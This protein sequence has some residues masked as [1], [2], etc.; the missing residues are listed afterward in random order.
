MT[1]FCFGHHILGSTKDYVG[2]VKFTNRND[3]H[4]G[5]LKCDGRSLDTTTYSDLFNVIGYSFGGSGSNFNLPKPGG[6]ILGSTGSGAGLTTRTMGDISGSETHT[7]TEE[8]L[9]EHTHII[10]VCGEHSHVVNDDNHRH[11]VDIGNINNNDFSADPGENPA[12]DAGS[13]NFVG[14]STTNQAFVNASVAS[15]GLHT[16]TAQTTGSNEPFSILQPTIFIGNTF[17]YSGLRLLGTRPH[18]G[19]VSA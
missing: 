9:P 7:L 15:N 3:D 2:D 4:Y 6:Y 1:S 17:I 13:S 18:I 16:H 10:D 14:T 12:A 11:V 8:Q 19:Q 5:W